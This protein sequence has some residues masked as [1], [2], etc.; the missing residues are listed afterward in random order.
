MEIIRLKDKLG[1]RQ[2]PTAELLLKGSIATLISVEGEGVKTISKMLTITRIYNSATA[3][4]VIRKGLAL[5][6]D[7]SARRTIGKSNL[8]KMPLQ[9]R[10]LSGLEVM[11]RGNLIMYIKLSQLFSKEHAKVINDH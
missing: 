2:L 3:V 1:T 9:Q 8:S 5:T 7:Y 4:G 11:H 6:R 10:V